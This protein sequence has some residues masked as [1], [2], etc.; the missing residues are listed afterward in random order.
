MTPPTIRILARGIGG[1]CATLMQGNT[2]HKI[3]EISIRYISLGHFGME[4]QNFFV[5]ILNSIFSAH[6]SIFAP[7]GNSAWTV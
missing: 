6:N 3:I 5:D 4:C 2:R 7:A 1:C